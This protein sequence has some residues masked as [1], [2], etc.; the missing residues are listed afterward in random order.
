[1]QLSSILASR[2]AISTDKGIDVV[3][4]KILARVF[5][6]RG[7]DRFGTYYSSDRVWFE[8]AKEI[9]NRPAWVGAYHGFTGQE[10]YQKEIKRIIKA[11]NTGVIENDDNTVRRTIRS[12]N[13][14]KDDKLNKFMLTITDK[15]KRIDNLVDMNSPY[16]G[17][18][19][20][21]V[22][23]INEVRDEIIR[24]LN[25]VWT[26]FGIRPLPLPSE[27]TITMDIYDDGS[28]HK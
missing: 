9:F 21:V 20:K 10:P 6:A 23:E 18:F 16:P 7:I 19:P 4:S 27:V 3:V 1:V 13:H 17:R 15:I 28:S 24:E 12:V 2:V 22:S 14:I 8:E 5:S 26:A 11:L 25:Q